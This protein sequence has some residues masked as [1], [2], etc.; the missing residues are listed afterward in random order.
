[1]DCV[2]LFC[3]IVDKCHALYIFR[4]LIT[5]I[6]YRKDFEVPYLSTS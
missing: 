1:M 3:T 4:D 5:L 2:Y 6:K